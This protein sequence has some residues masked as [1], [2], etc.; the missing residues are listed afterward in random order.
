M[1]M[2]NLP[3]ALQQAMREIRQNFP[4]PYYWAPFFLAGQI[5]DSARLN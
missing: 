1:A 5:S 2:G 4:H 3:L